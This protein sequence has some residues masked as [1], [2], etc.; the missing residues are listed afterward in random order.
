MWLTTQLGN[1]KSTNQVSDPKFNRID[2]LYDINVN[3]VLYSR[4]FN[5]LPPSH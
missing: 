2:L 4:L 1:L 3:E 5:L